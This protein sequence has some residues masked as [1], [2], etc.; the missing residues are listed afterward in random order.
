MPRSHCPEC[1]E[2]IGGEEQVRIID[3]FARAGRET[4]LIACDHCGV[5]LGAASAAD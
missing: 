5:V 2:R 1:G 3:L 4:A